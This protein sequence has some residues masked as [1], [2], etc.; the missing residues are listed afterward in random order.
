MRRTEKGRGVAGGHLSLLLVQQQ[1]VI[2][3]SSI[4]DVRM[5]MS[6]SSM[7]WLSTLPCAFA[8]QTCRVACVNKALSGLWMIRVNDHPGTVECP[9]LFAGCRNMMLDHMRMQNKGASMVD[10]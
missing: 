3:P 7:R 8:I 2:G 1:V 4:K 6:A 10:R 9:L 5:H